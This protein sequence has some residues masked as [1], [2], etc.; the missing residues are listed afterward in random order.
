[1]K[2]YIKEH[3][4]LG[5]ITLWL[6]IMFVT[7]MTGLAGEYQGA[8]QSQAVLAQSEEIPFIDSMDMVYQ[9]GPYN[10]YEFGV[11]WDPVTFGPST[12]IGTQG[13]I[14]HGTID[15]PVEVQMSKDQEDFRY[16]ITVASV[17]SGL[18][19]LPISVDS[20]YGLSV[21]KSDEDGTS[22][23]TVTGFEKLTSATV[24]PFK[25]TYED[26]NYSLI[27]IQFTPQ[28]SPVTSSTINVNYVDDD[29]NG[30]IVKTDTI[31]GNV[32]DTGSYAVTAPDKYQLASRQ[33]DSINYKIQ[34]TNPDLTVH[35]KHQTES[36]ETLTKV[37]INYEGAGNLTPS[38]KSVDMHWTG[39]KDK[40]T[41]QTTNWSTSHLPVTINTPSVNGYTADH[42]SVIIEK[43]TGQATAPTDKN[44]T[45][46][47]TSA[48]VTPSNPD[49]G[50]FTVNQGTPISKGGNSGAS[51]NPMRPIDPNGTGLPNYAVVKGSV[52]YA[53]KKIY[54]YRNANFKSSE[55][56]AAYSK[57]KR[58]NRPMFV[59][60]GYERSSAGALRYKV[61]DVNHGKKTAGKGGYLT[62]NKKYVVNGYYKT[63]PSNH[64]MTVI[65]TNGIHAYKNANLTGKAKT[66]K[67][68]THIRVKRIVKHNLTTRYQLT[69]GYYVT[70]NKKL[71]IQG[72]Y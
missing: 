50:T 43:V 37:I 55:R 13:P 16:V 67:R 15:H 26:G 46:K 42:N 45:V 59:V 25:V 36:A 56:I 51:W 71:I 65:S 6:V 14:K 41:N 22:N 2:T 24:I 32:N 29:N 35:L 4:H 3:S 17:S 53:T 20:K 38:A 23:Y 66:Y 49:S 7:M 64:R 61:R 5:T 40:V 68:G 31:K 58:I 62:A 57:V 54:L 44:I 10:T 47:F 69:N 12:D 72:N 52:V 19:P 27:Y 18:N 8:K 48:S 11:Y 1:M 28:D 30:V 60:I 34:N 39:T 33:A 70:A 9:A 63:L 21:S